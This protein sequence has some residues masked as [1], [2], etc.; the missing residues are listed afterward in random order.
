MVMLMVIIKIYEQKKTGE[1]MQ[2]QK[3]DKHMIADL[4]G[5]QKRHF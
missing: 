2:S 4:H 5:Y 1:Y 3:A